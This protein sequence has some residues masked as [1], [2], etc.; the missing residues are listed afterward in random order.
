MRFDT[1][2]SIII[3]HTSGFISEL[4][5]WLVDGSGFAGRSGVYTASPSD[6]AMLA[7]GRTYNVG[8]DDLS[9]RSVVWVRCGDAGLNW[10]SSS[11]SSLSHG[12]GTAARGDS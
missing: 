9:S 4:Y 8:G 1:V 10:N 7:L 11:S 12:S 6:S 5:V 3:L 2:S